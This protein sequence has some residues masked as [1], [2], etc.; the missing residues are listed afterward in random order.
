MDI[1]DTIRV[2]FDMDIGFQPAGRI[3]F[4]LFR[5]V[6]PITV[7]NFRALCTGEKGVCKETRKPMHYKNCQFHRI[8]KVHTCHDR[9]NNR[10]L[11]GIGGGGYYA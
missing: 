11:R 3:T 8:I 2:W 7:E 10:V 6:V 1:S 9:H 5:G 4:E